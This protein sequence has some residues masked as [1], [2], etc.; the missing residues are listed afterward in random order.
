MLGTQRKSHEHIFLNRRRL[1]SG[2]YMVEPY[3]LHGVIVLISMKLKWKVTE[4]MQIKS[5]A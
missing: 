2:V 1:S 5:I 3:A 4:F